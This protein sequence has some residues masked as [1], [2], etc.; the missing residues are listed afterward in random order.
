MPDVNFDE[1]L[2]D[3]FEEYWRETMGEPPPSGD[4]MEAKVYRF[5]EATWDAA[6]DILARQM[7]ANHVGQEHFDLASEAALTEELKKL[8]TDLDE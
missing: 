2:P 8:R 6:L 3:S 5:G 4:S 1:D 7:V